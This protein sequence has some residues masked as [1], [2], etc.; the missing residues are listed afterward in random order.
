LIYPTE[1]VWSYKKGK[2]PFRHL[3]KM[4]QRKTKIPR[5]WI[6][7]RGIFL[8]PAPKRR[9]GQSVVVN[10]RIFLLAINFLYSLLN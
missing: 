8:E 5:P 9:L 10:Q 4:I 1:I 7:V 2:I 6:H 3:G